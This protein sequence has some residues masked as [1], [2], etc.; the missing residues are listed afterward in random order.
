MKKRW[1][2]IGIISAC[3]VLFVVLVMVFLQSPFVKRKILTS[4]QQSLQKGQG[5]QLAV[6]SFDYNLLKLQFDLKGIQAQK[7]DESG[8]PPVF[9]AEKIRL[10]IPLSLILKRRIRIQD[11]EIVNPE[12]R[13]QVDLDGNSNLPFQ[14]GAKKSSQAQPIIPEFLIEHLEVKNAQINFL[15]KRNDLELGLS[16]IWIKGEGR[17]YGKHSLL[18]EMRR[19]GLANYHGRSISLEKFIFQAEQDKEGLNIEKFYLASAKNEIELSGRIVD[20]SSL[21]FDGSIQGHFDAEDIRSLM[22]VD[23]PL[24][25][26]IEF[27]SSL[28]GPLKGIEARINLISEDLSYGKIEKIGMSALLHWKDRALD[29]LSLDIREEKGEIHGQGILHPLNWTEGNHLNLEWKNLDVEPFMELIQRPEF[30]SA[31]TT[32]SMMVS[33][34]GFSFDDVSGQCDVRLA[35]KEIREIPEKGMPLTGRIVAKAVSGQLDIT[36]LDISTL[37]ADLKGKFHLSSEKLSGDFGLELQSVRKIMP[38]ILA[39]ASDLDETYVQRLDLDGPLSI[40]ATLGG[41]LKEPRVRFNV[42]SANL[43]ALKTKNLRIDGTALYDLR[44]IQIES[45]LVED[46]EGRIEMTGIYPLKPADQSMRFDIQLSAKSFPINNLKVAENLDR[47]KAELDIDFEAQGNFEDPHIKTKGRIR[48]LSMGIQAMS[49]LDF[50][51]RSERDVILFKVEA[52]VYASSIDGT[53][54]LKSPHVLNADLSIDKMRVED[55]KDRFPLFREKDFSGLVTADVH[56]NTELRDPRKTFNCEVRIEEVQ[57]RSGDRLVR[58]DGPIL[59]SF[60]EETIR[61]DRLELVGGGTR[62]KAE[63]SLPLNVESSS[64]ILLSAEVDL[65]LLNDFLPIED[66]EG[67]LKMESQISGS[68]SDLEVAAVL[69]MREAR[70]QSPRFPL[71]VEDVQAHLEIK[72]NLLRIDSFS[73]RLAGARLGLTGDI[74]FASLPFQLPV[75]FHDFEERE[76][77]LVLTLENW[78]PS[79][80][81]TLIPNQMFQQIKGTISGKF[82]L[83]GKKLRL[84]DISG[85]GLFEIFVLDL[86]GIS[87]KQDAPSQIFLERGK[88]SVENLS[89]RNRENRLNINGSAS[90]TGGEDLDLSIDGELDMSLVAVFLQEGA[91]SGKTRFQIHIAS[92]YKK[93]KI[94]GFVDIQEGRYQRI[95]PR[96]L[97]EQVNGEI[98]FKG[99]QAEIEKIQGVL[100]GG[101]AIINGKILFDGLTI[102]EADVVLKNENSLFDFPRGL[103]SQVSGDLKFISDGKDHQVAG[104]IT[105]LDARYRDDFRVGTAVFNLLRKDSSRETFR[106]LNPFLKKLNLKIDI[107]I[108]NNFIIDNNIAKSEVAA[109]LQL[110]G[111][112]Y[113][114]SLSGRASIAEGGEVYFNQNTFFVEQGTVDFI[115]P[116]RIEPELNLNARTQV[117]EYDIRLTVQGTPDKLTASLVSDPPLSEPNIISLLVMG[118]TLESASAP[119]LSVAGST[120][121]SYLNNAITGRIEQAT[122]RALGLDSVRIDAG[123][124]STEENPEARITV[125]QHL[126]RDF[127]LVF[128]QDLKDTRNQMWMLNYNPYK[129]FNI[130]GLKRDNNELNLA[131]RHE[132]QF[133]LK[134]SSQ[135][136]PENTLGKKNFIVGNIELEGE[137]ALPESEIFQR[138]K[139]KKGKKIDF[140]ALQEAL[141]RIRKLYQKNDYLSFSLAARR[142]ETN[143]RLDII[144][145]ID[146][147]QKIS[148]EYDGAPIPKKL[149]K[150]IVETWV[151]SPLGQLALEDIEQRILVHFMEKRYYEVQV[152][153]SERRG[154]K[155]ERTL[156][157]NTIK[158]RRYGKPKIEI[159][160]NRAISKKLIS[161]HIEKSGLI[162][163]AFYKPTEWVKSIEDLY[164]RHGYLRPKVHLPV[165]Q[166]KQDEKKAFVEVSIDEGIRFMV[167][168]VKLK[169]QQFFKENQILGEIGIRP[170]DIV[171]LDRF[172]QA[173]HKI[174]EMYVQNGFNDVR[175][176]TDVQVNADK[177]TVD[178]ESNVQENKR[179]MIAEIKIEGNKLTDEKIIRRELMFDKGEVLNFRMINETRK[180][181]YDLGIFGRVSI[182]IIPLEQDEKKPAEVNK[183]LDNDVQYCRVVINL[184]E[185]KPYRLRY[186][187]QYDTESSYGVLANL[188]NRNF[189]GN[190]NLLGASFRLNRDERDTRAFFRSPYFF[191]R[192]I[193]TEILLFNNRTTKPAFTLDRTGFTLQQQMKIKMSNVISYN[194]SFEKIDTLYPVFE[195]IQNVDTTDRISTLNAAFSRDTRDDIMNATRGMFLS[196]NIRVAPGFLGSKT[197]FIRYFGQ[198]NTYQR[199][200]DFLIYAS[201]VRIGLGKGLNEDLPASERFFAGGGTTI[202]GFKKDELGPRD[203]SSNLPL[204]GDAVFILNQE[205]RFPILKKLGGVVFL[206]LGNVYQKIS[207]FSFFDVR[208]T[209]GFGFRLHTP[210]VLVRFDWGFKLD[211]RP[212]ESLS[213]IFFSIGQAF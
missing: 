183:E 118:R 57:I 8:M 19:A 158:S 25:G 110:T 140:A 156:V 152:R 175:I 18:L 157:F 120:A 174:Q 74:P 139:L 27:R 87:F 146:S 132:I 185:L 31:Q 12:I 73:G 129:S 104:K 159:K 89:L 193:S 43:Q 143:G 154:E 131:L 20:L 61:T 96:L 14:T 28:K 42:K 58:N 136:I 178:L 81:K 94:Q 50:E 76:A 149:K 116:I 153:S 2:K 72:K 135:L 141:E 181:L 1:K 170:G 98:K 97:L 121:L 184:D 198:F 161:A 105:I 48:Q 205:L 168:N 82:E 189:L 167:E 37:D 79:F 40:S 5:I 68:L 69:D 180:R 45:L 44:S 38:L 125:G 63:G 56:M 188:V 32:G 177:G 150:E 30:F 115:N 101:G 95:Y 9:R 114:P 86:S 194:Y 83:E 119:V 100:N 3:A 169:G 11:I 103:H 173:D 127:E 190:A 201:S 59:L 78:D 111:T 99:D 207:D 70:F 144:L 90:L 202:R 15:D 66:S 23:T 162:N 112:P 117:K 182:D 200:S 35:P 85:K 211:R 212:G 196:Q 206:D 176:Q 41:N 145:Q 147:G 163:S 191:S 4:L 65:S 17:D 138:L 209:A 192:K 187:L 134:A 49:D 213:Q 195:G 208:K 88:L 75:K 142:E 197:P 148:L 55:L 137:M 155:G 203:P 133:G 33:W 10:N 77:K 92:S 80:L 199:L 160:G 60:G 126:S 91:F 151:G 93:P 46:G 26:K 53:F 113:N 52:P 54:S 34:D 22:A 84:E 164:I 108:P 128:S 107:G 62:I 179:G 172:N 165:V 166:L 21:L 16:E 204:G 51:A 71:P 186:G 106:E 124:V 47:I 6:E 7:L 109:D 67:S 130:Q 102:H 210:F 122:A 39:F 29:V 123:L 24:S 13:I 171:S 36:L 64:K